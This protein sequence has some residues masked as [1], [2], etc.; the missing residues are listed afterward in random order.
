MCEKHFD[1]PRSEKYFP[2]TLDLEE[3]QP[4]LNF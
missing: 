4:T 3:N 1:I 2:S